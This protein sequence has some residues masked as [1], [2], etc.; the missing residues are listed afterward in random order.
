[1]TTIG[2]LIGMPG[3]SVNSPACLV[4]P[5]RVGVVT[6]NWSYFHSGRSSASYLFQYALYYLVLVIRVC[7]C[8]LWRWMRVMFEW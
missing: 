3:P 6:V 2:I 4:R 7:V 8:G 5:R 1:M